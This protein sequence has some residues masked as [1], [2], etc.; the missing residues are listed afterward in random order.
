MFR[1]Y[2]TTALRNLARNKLYAAINIL[3]LTVGFAAALLTARRLMA[4]CGC[5]P[6]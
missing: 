1:N 6:P 5:L 3:G 4:R 2:L